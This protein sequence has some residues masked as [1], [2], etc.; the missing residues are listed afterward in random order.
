MKR[1]PFHIVYLVIPVILFACSTTREVKKPPTFK[2]AEAT[3][4]KGVSIIGTP[5]NSTTTFTTEDQEAVAYLRL[6]NLSGNHKLRWEWSAPDGRVYYTTGSS[7]ETGIDKFRKDV[8]VW[9]RL[10]IKGEKAAT[11]PGRWSVRAF[12]DESA[13]LVKEFEIKETSVIAPPAEVIL[14]P[15]R[16][17]AYAVIIGIDYEGRGGDIPSLKY[18]SLDAQKVYDLFTDPR[19]GGIP[20]ENV[21]LL[22]NKMATRVNMLKALRK[23]KDWDGFVYVYYSGH[24]APKIKEDKVIDAYLAP[25]EVDISSADALEDTGIRVSQL[26]EFVNS[27]KAKG[28]MVAL[29]ACYSGG[30]KSLTPK[31]AKPLVGM[32]ATTEI[33]KAAGT[34]KVIMTSSAMNEPSWEDDAELKGSIFTH[35][36]LEGMEGKA[37]YNAWVSVNEITNYLK[38]KVPRASRK[39]KGQ[40]Q[41]PQI[42][43]EGSFAVTRNWEMEEN[44][45]KAEVKLKSAYS[46]ELIT[47]EQLNRAMGE[48]RS[49]TRSKPLQSFLEGK[50]DEKAFGSSY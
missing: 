8:T 45:K 40:E 42:S 16:E 21:I 18:P 39:L 38:E 15:L 32:L 6:G 26:Q 29:D 12:M 50:I 11:L 24:G 41:T 3:L 1:F 33:M 23:V 22:Q 25:Y 46:K 30:G 48:M 9:H 27:S 44:I 2:L 47:L 14:P 49:K 17:D 36:L 35:Y 7:I 19:Y 34:G 5:V 37:G 4:A 20:K 28:I 10:A 13:I 43:G 31:G